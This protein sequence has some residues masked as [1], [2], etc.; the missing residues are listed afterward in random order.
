MKRARIG[1]IAATSLLWASAATA[2]TASVVN[3]PPALAPLAEEP[4]AKVIVGP[5]LQ[6]LEDVA[7]HPHEKGFALGHETGHP[8]RR[9]R[10]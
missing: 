9:G 1:V 3:G 4:P 5:V 7:I 6:G 10:A 2:Q 8:A